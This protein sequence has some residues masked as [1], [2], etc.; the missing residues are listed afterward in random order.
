MFS[1]LSNCVVIGN[2][3]CLLFTIELYVAAHLVQG[4]VGG[5]VDEGVIAVLGYSDGAVGSQSEQGSE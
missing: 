5:Q 3:R 1:P 2:M 4:L